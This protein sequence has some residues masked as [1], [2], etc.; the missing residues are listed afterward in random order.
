M[1]VYSNNHSNNLL[2]ALSLA[3]TDR[4]DDALSTTLGAGANASAALMSIGAR[5]GE[6]IDQLA[7]VLDLNHSTT[8]RIVDR[9]EQSGW[10]RRTRG[11]RDGRAVSLTLTRSG[12]TNSRRL[13]T[14]RN[15]VL[16]E[17]TVG[18]TERET[19]VLGRLLHK[20]LAGMPADRREARHMCRLCEHAICEGPDC[21]VGSAVKG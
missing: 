21:P 3:L 16:N 4:T 8:V 10:V 20:M 17:V 2:G 13:T 11:G 15:A 6:S 12:Q 14:A 5:P 1:T 19:E 9:L 18:L 7:R